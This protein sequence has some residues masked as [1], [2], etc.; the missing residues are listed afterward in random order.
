MPDE[1]PKC[2]SRTLFYSIENRKAHILNLLTSSL[3]FAVSFI[4]VHYIGHAWTTSNAHIEG[5]TPFFS[6]NGVDSLLGTTNWSAWKIGFIYLMPSLTGIIA[7]VVGLVSLQLART[8]QVHF[9]TFMFWLSINGLLMYSSYIAT[10]YLSGLNFNSKFFTGFV[11]LYAWLYWEDLTIYGVL[12]FQA[13]ICL[14]IIFYLGKVVLS[15]NYSSSLLKQKN[16]RIIVWTNVVL[17]PFT[18][19]VVIVIA[20][21]FPMDFGYQL[22]R[23]AC[24]IP[25]AI[26]MAVG[27]QVISTENIAIVK[28][29]MEGLP[30]IVWV[31]GTGVL[32]LISRTL[33]SISS[34]P[35]W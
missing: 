21:T 8:K 9:R 34:G 28:G 30:I 13:L 11:G 29:G 5:Y 18:I 2:L 33:L 10:G 23:I 22:V 17:I 3:Y 12:F 15:L 25:I 26:A 6:Y 14:P 31:I 20:A 32:I 1:F 16:G 24:F 27:M 19:G 7:L 4:T 35:L